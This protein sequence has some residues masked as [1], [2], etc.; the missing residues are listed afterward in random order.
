[1]GNAMGAPLKGL[2][3]ATKASTQGISK[4][5]GQVSKSVTGMAGQ[6]GKIGKVISAVQ[7]Y[8]NMLKNLLGGKWLYVLLAAL[9]LCCCCPCIASCLPELC[10]CCCSCCCEAGGCAI[11]SLKCCCGDPC[12]VLCKVCKCGLFYKKRPEHWKDNGHRWVGSKHHHHHGMHNHDTHGKGQNG[13]A[14][15]SN[16][17]KSWWDGEASSGEDEHGAWVSS[18]DNAADSV[19]IEIIINGKHSM[20]APSYVQAPASMG[21]PGSA[22]TNLS[23]NSWFD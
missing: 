11:K 7:K 15:K 20:A 23:P 13:A 16:C 6:L 5:M 4:A 14:S 18:N 19:D 10:S 1:M 22:S 12:K 3:S 17:W 21:A 9:V 8:F 2:S